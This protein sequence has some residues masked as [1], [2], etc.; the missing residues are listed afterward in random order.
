M[1]AVPLLALSVVSY[2]FTSGMNE[3]ITSRFSI[4]RKSRFE[5]PFA[6]FSYLP[7]VAPTSSTFSIIIVR[8]F[9]HHKFYQNPRI[10]YLLIYVLFKYFSIFFE[11]RILVNFLRCTIIVR[12]IK[13]LGLSS[14][15]NSAFN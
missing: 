9:K 12:N 10:S 8:F 2:N 5:Y 14:A 3:F 7:E 13:P 15:T 1:L 11:K 4:L 6:N